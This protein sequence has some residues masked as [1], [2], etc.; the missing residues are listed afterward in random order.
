MFEKSGSIPGARHLFRYVTNQPPKANSAVHPSAVGKWVP[1]SAGKAKAGMVY[2][3]SGW[4]RGVQVKLWDPLR[5]R[6]IPERLR[7]VFTTRRYTNTV[8]TSK[9]GCADSEWFIKHVHSF[10]AWETTEPSCCGQFIKGDMFTS[11]T[12]LMCTML[13]LVD[14]RRRRRR[15]K[16]NQTTPL[17]ANISDVPLPAANGHVTLQATNGHVPRDRN[18]SGNSVVPSETFIGCKQQQLQPRHRPVS[19]T[20]DDPRH[21]HHPQHQQHV[22]LTDDATSPTERNVNIETLGEL[23]SDDDDSGFF[24]LSLIFHYNCSVN[25]KLLKQSRA[26][27]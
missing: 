17:P 2:S 4:K 10:F 11:F 9:F 22:S 12:D 21:H 15:V 6:A 27:V 18:D 1:A 7:G 20:N 5:T 23:M 25:N 24:L 8:W 14:S 13:C 19:L 3:D 26:L 16:R